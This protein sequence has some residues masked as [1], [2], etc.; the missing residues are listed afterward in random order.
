MFLGASLNLQWSRYFGVIPAAAISSQQFETETPCGPPADFWDRSQSN[1]MVQSSGVFFEG[2]GGGFKYFLIFTP[3]QGNDPIW[4]IFFKWVE[5]TNQRMMNMKFDACVC[6]YTDWDDVE[7][8]LTLTRWFSI[9]I[10]YDV[11]QLCLELFAIYRTNA[12]PLRFT[13]FLVIPLLLVTSR[14]KEHKAFIFWVGDPKPN[15][16]NLPLGLWRVATHMMSVT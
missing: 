11:I 15:I 16:I 1:P 3:T 10:R 4:L 2:L 8:H 6:E 14:K 12:S 7:L 5:T 9:C 13:V